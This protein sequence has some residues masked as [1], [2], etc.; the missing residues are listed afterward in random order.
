MGT[1]RATKT[2]VPAENGHHTT[3]GKATQESVQRGACLP[4][5]R[6][7][8]LAPALLRLREHRL[9]LWLRALLLRRRRLL[10]G[11]QQASRHER[12]AADPRQRAQLLAAKQQ[13]GEAGGP[14]R[15]GGEHDR[16]LGGGHV[17]LS[18]QGGSGGVRLVSVAPWAA[19]AARR[20]SH[21][22]VC[23]ERHG[24]DSK[25]SSNQ[26]S[27]VSSSSRQQQR[28]LPGRAGMTRGLRG[29]VPTTAGRP[30]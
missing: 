14:Q 22:H 4:H 19:A 30:T 7:M 18:L 21:I 12:G 11:R 26:R 3:E 16:G 1:T 9:R 25:R 15:L 5:H 2:G 8:R 27:S 29:P 17:L 20:G 28:C 23:G 10:R 24:S 6:S 13:P